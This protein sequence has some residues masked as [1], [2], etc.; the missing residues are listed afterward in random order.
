MIPQEQEWDNKKYTL[1]KIY[2]HSQ[3]DQGE[4]KS[5]MFKDKELL[6]AQDNIETWYIYDK[7]DSTY[8]LYRRIE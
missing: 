3:N 8:A 6:E 5:W 2:P 7:E 1:H 4:Q